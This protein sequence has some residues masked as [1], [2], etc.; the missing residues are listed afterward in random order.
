MS[1][2]SPAVLFCL[3]PDSAVS[4]DMRADQAGMIKFRTVLGV[5]S[6]FKD[7]SIGGWNTLTFSYLF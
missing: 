4:P 5:S 1:A 2:V 6:S 3:K 7:K